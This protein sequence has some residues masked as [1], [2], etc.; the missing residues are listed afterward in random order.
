MVVVAPIHLEDYTPWAFSLPTIDLDV[1]IQSDHVVVS[2]RFE[3][4]PKIP[5][6]LLQLRGVDLVI[7]AIAINEVPLCSS[8]W[9]FEDDL[10]T[11]AKCPKRS[12]ILST[13]CRI[14]PYNNSSLEGLYASCGLLSTQCEAEGFRRISLHP[15]RPDVLSRWRVRIEASQTS[16][17][18]LLSNGNVVTEEFLGSDRHAVI[19]EDPF[20]KPSYLFALV[21]GDLREVRDVYITASGRNVTLRIHVE[22]GDEVFTDHA[23]ASLKRSMAWDESVY[24]LEYDLDEYNIVAIRH[25]NMGAMEN[26]SLNIFNSKL[27]L[28]DAETATDTELKRIESVIAHEYFHNWSGNRITCRDWFQLSL[29]EG[30]TVFRDQSFTADLHSAAVKRIEDVVMLRNAQFSED[31]GPTAHPVKP[32][33]YQAIDNFY[34]TTIYEKGAELIRMLHT[35]LGK[36]RFMR[37]MATYV[38]RFD[39]M[40]ATTEDFV[41]AIADG[42][43][44]NG[45]PLGFDLEQFRQWYYQAGTPQLKVEYQWN[46][47]LGQMTVQFRQTTLPTPGQLEKQ[48]LVLPLAVALIGPE[49]RVGEEQLVVMESE[50]MTIKLQGEANV[51]APALS[52]P[53]RFSA[54]L[55]IQIE[56]SLKE[57]LQLLAMDDD[58]FCRWNAGQS[59]TGQVILAR[60]RGERKHKVESALIKAIAQRMAACRPKESADLATLLALPGMAE[61]EALETP[62]DPLTLY[63]AMRSWISELGRQLQSPLN[64]LLSFSRR[65]WSLAWP[66]GQG[67]RALTGL[68]WSWLIAAGDKEARREALEAVAGPSMTLARAALRALQPLELVERDQALN[69]FYERWHN[70]PIIF[71]AWLALEASTPRVDGLKRVQQLLNHSHFDPLAPNSLRAVLGGFAANVPAFHALDGSGYRFMAD[72]VAA[73]DTRNPITAS[74]MAKVFSRYKSYGLERQQVMREAIDRLASHTLS[75]NTA[76]VVQLLSL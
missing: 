73:I 65:D 62:V 9:V 56:Q 4:Q 7:E 71:D 72:Q 48:P 55:K 22:T 54:P 24:N 74:R 43:C 57:N 1:N 17:P 14:N 33:K 36:K 42:A 16:F 30:L 28:A 61:L 44:S 66:E 45:Q 64:H 27:I 75:I 11:I 38:N 76:E 60:A 49:G 50:A 67:G 26:K 5:D 68:A 41:Q 47:A 21:A 2:S 6:A 20:P 39:G 29:K 12:F 18:V 58:P 32:S 31:A 10:L 51:P 34:T 23:M 46:E 40:A 53:R 15:D 59:L 3:L 25:F 70:K 69:C 63:K 35:L 19:W 52:L 8:D 37:G 13:R